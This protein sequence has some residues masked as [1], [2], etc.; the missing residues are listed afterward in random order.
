MKG[1]IMPGST[2]AR[3]L[4]HIDE[5]FAY[6]DDNPP[7]RIYDPG[8]A[9]TAKAALFAKC[10]SYKF[11]VLTIKGCLDLGASTI[12]VDVEL[13]GISLASCSLSQANQSCK[14]GGSVDGFKAEVTLTFESGPPRLG[15]KGQLC[16]PI[17]GCD[18]FET[19]LNL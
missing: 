18:Q 19:E 12:S 5:G 15:I 1:K 14:V 3:P 17:A 11:G 7:R 16:A 9:A 6:H 10:V 13:L 8:D 2:A 4:D